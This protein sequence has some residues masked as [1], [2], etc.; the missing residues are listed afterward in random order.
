MAVTF[1]DE[2]PKAAAG[3]TFLDDQPSGGGVTF[4]EDDPQMSP[5]IM[6]EALRA[7]GAAMTGYEMLT[8]PSRLDWSAANEQH[9]AEAMLA[10][11]Q[12]QGEIADITRREGEA[13][14]AA[15]V[16]IGPDGQPVELKSEPLRKLAEAEADIARYTPQAPTVP[17]YETFAKGGGTAQDYTKQFGPI[18]TPQEL[19]VGE[20][21]AGRMQR[22]NM[23]ET[24]ATRFFSS[25]AA[26]GAEVA[27][28]VAPGMGTADLASN[29]QAR[30]SEATFWS[31]LNKSTG[32]DIGRG[33]GA[34]AGMMAGN[35]AGKPGMVVGALRAAADTRGQ[36]IAQG[37]SETEAESAAAKTFPMML[38]F[39]AG[40]M[41]AAKAG[42]A[43]VPQ[44]ASAL[45]RGLVG[46]GV[47]TAANV[48]M[49]AGISAIEG[50]PYTA[51]NFTM[52]ALFGV[53]GGIHAAKS[54]AETLRPLSPDESRIV[55]TRGMDA[56]EVPNEGRLIAD[57]KPSL[58][59]IRQ[60][61]TTPPDP[62]RELGPG[63]A[64]IEE[65]GA[66][67]TIGAKN[68]SVDAQRAE[69]G[70]PPLMSEAKKSDPV[71]WEN[72]E[73]RIEENPELPRQL[74]EEIIEGKKTSVTDEEQSALLW[75]MI[76]LR[77]SRDMEAQRAN[78]LNL[79]PEQQAEHLSNFE[80][81]ESDLQKTEE[82]D[83][84]IGTQSGRALRARR[85]MANEDFTLAAMEARERSA[86]GEPLT[87][88]ETQ[89]IKAEHDEISRLAKEQGKREA[90]LELEAERK[91]V[92][93]KIA[94]VGKFSPGLLE[95][96]RKWIEA[97]ESQI[98]AG[99]ER[100]R[101]LVGKIMGKTS[102]NPL[103]IG[104]AL[105]LT[106]I[107]A[108]EALVKLGRAGVDLA[109][110]SADMV[111][112]FGDAVSPYLKKAWDMA[113]REWNGSP[114]KPRKK[115]TSQMAGEQEAAVTAQSIEGAIRETAGDAP[116]VAS[117]SRQ[118]KELAREYVKAG[119]DTVEALETRL[120][121]F[122]EPLIPGVTK[123]ELRNEFSDYGKS[124]A[125]PT[126]PLRVR[127]SQLRQESQKVSQLEALE[128]QMAPLR[129]GTQRVEQ[130]AR[131]RE[132]T[133][134]INELK[135]QL[136]IVDGDPKV[137]LR[138]ILEAT[139][140]RIENRIADLQYEIAKGER[141]VKTKTPSPTNEKIEALRT[142]LKAVK[143]EHEAALGPREVTEAQLLAARKSSLKRQIEEY[144]DRISKGDFEPRTRKSPLDISKDK[145]AVR[146]AAEKERVIKDFQKRQNDYR[147]AQRS[148][149][150]KFKDVVG[151]SLA[152][153]RTVITSGDVS[154]P[155]RQGGFMLMGDLFLNPKR[156][157][158]Q[159]GNM[160]KQLMSQK[161]FDEDQARLKLRPN[162]ELYDKSGLHI[163]DPN[164]TFT[165]REE[166]MRS[167]LA[168][169]IP[170]AGRVVK[171]SNRAYAGFLNRQRADAFDAFVD[172][173]GGKD[174]ISADDA[175]FL[176]EAVNDMTGRSDVPGK[177]VG[178]ANFLARYL[179]SPRY[180]MSR[181]KLLVGAPIWRGI[182]SGEISPKAR[183]IIALQY[184]RFA[185]GV[186]AFYGLA[187]LAGAT[188]EDDPRSA[189][190]AKA[191]FGN[192]RIDPLTGLQQLTVLMSRIAS[193]KTIR[194]GKTMD[195]RGPE[196][197]FGSPSALDIT[198]NFMRS[199]LAPIPG[200]AMDFAQ[201]EGADF[202]PVTV[203]GEAKKLLVPI[204]YQDMPDIY[205]EHG[206]MRGTVMSVM[207]LL[208]FGVQDYS[209]KK[210]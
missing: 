134:K 24:A 52:D 51:E 132:L 175:K 83:R 89:R 106:K 189:D 109:K 111:S 3:V 1:L 63:A 148:R 10:Q 105:E 102:A 200:V 49:S 54:P 71:M 116:T 161:G 208:G 196:K 195:I 202:E 73:K 123:A 185:L 60:E 167:N 55:A 117:L 170:I 38:G 67:R 43:L 163:S 98:D 50:A 186:A 176:A 149:L 72:T 94:E 153:T 46:G 86:K 91:S 59:Q 42:G 85:I 181:A 113:Q 53:M 166:T 58:E 182:G 11:Q 169:E 57:P 84:K 104:E 206:P 70:L 108:N 95:R 110:F 37:G 178:V 44:E 127:L 147:L 191:R 128:I 162:S 140:K 4:L 56:L 41:A 137:R 122:F 2:E 138:S 192:T 8:M 180:L 28:T 187:K 114:A 197:K 204:S 139:Q 19:E 81:L 7:T 179:F 209:P 203:G 47:G 152:A 16:S 12:A 20:V 177:A 66:Q 168:E 150:Q 6:D 157:I 77:N 158:Q 80:R 92:E 25:I 165:Q 45:T 69:R 190:F 23:A 129:T 30:A 118:I 32:G 124:K 78:D 90:A 194:G 121:E 75:R 136:G 145:E 26:G 82:A 88:E 87:P 93:E 14:G 39:M 154:A 210:K 40:S 193:G 174:K 201:G 76:D 133:K 96:A 64:N 97:K 184:G 61:G 18:G 22:P 125:A 131:A 112:Q 146:L 183:A 17:S 9:R 62:N 31:G 79:T 141:A 119:A 101:I 100:M 199:K 142:E 120:H 173:M 34:F 198:A 144:Q 126:E 159:L 27:R 29:L 188:I 48:G 103:P 107:L 155:F 143:A 74:T 65:F 5:E 36:V 164:G 35:P 172:M 21:A 207:S 115:T 205:K 160:F 156:A 13:G 151:D 68:A 171:A 99:R 135:R 15:L 33:I 130:S